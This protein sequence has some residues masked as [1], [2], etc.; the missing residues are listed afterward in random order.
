[1][2]RVLNPN[3]P[4]RLIYGKWAKDAKRAKKATDHVASTAF[5]RVRDATSAIQSIPL[6]EGRRIVSDKRRWPHNSEWQADR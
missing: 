3:P 6:G 2:A 5:L 4:V 1:L